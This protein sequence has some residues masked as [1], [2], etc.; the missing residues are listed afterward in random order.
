MHNEEAGSREVGH[1]MYITEEKL[2]YVI[3]KDKMA[4]KFEKKNDFLLIGDHVYIFSLVCTLTLELHIT[5]QDIY[6]L[7][8][9]APL[10][11]QEV[12]LGRLQ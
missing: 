9:F 12:T 7:N 4:Y 5:S 1:K 10:S 8:L 2:E 11:N 6:L 3:G